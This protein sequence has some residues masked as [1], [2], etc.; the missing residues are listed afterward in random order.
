AP[1]ATFNKDYWLFVHVLDPQGEQMWTDDNQ[2]PRPTSKWNAGETIEDK[3]TIFVPNYP[4]IGEA[5]VRLV[6]YDMQSGQ[7][8]VLNA[9]GVGPRG[10]PVPQIQNAASPGQNLS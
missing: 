9:P 4:Y 5:Q 2:P 1:N 8:L 10:D 6:L 7:R 3:R